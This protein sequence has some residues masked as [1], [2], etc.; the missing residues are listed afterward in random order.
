[1]HVVLPHVAVLAEGDVLSV[2]R[3]LV[4]YVCCGERHVALDLKVVFREVSGVVRPAD[5]HVPFLLGAESCDVLFLVHGHEIVPVDFPVRHERDLVDHAVD[6]ADVLV[7]PVQPGDDPLSEM[8]DIVVVGGQI[9]GVVVV[10]LPVHLGGGSGLVAVLVQHAALL[11]EPDERV[12]HDGPLLVDLLHE[13]ALTGV[14]EHGLQPEVAVGQLIGEDLVVPREVE[15]PQRSPVD[16]S[17]ACISRP[18]LV[19]VGASGGVGVP[20]E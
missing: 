7:H 3:L 18:L 4:G 14:V 9:L 1:M 20:V 15:V 8:L 16:L 2:D 6:H 11:R 17:V 10:A 5:E 13:A 12:L 19:E